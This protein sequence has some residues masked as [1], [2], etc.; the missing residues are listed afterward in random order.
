MTNTRIFNRIFPI[1]ILVLFIIVFSSQ[2]LALEYTGDK[3]VLING[4]P[5]VNPNKMPEEFIVGVT[6]DY[7]SPRFNGSFQKYDISNS[8]ITY[9]TKWVDNNE[10]H[11]DLYYTASLPELPK[12]LN[13]GENVSLN[14]RISGGGDS[15]EYG[16]ACSAMLQFEYRASGVKLVGGT[17]YTICMDFKEGNIAPYFVVPEIQ[18]GGKI[19]ISAFLW[20][21][22]ACLVQWVYEAGGKPVDL[23]DIEEPSI[24]S[25]PA[26]GAPELIDDAD[27]N[28]TLDKIEDIESQMPDPVAE[29]YGL[30]KGGPDMPADYVE[31]ISGSMIPWATTGVIKGDVF[32]FQKGVGKWKGP[33]GPNVA[34]F[35]GDTIWTNEG[36]WAEIV[37]SGS[38][39]FAIAQRTML[40]TGIKEKGWLEWGAMLIWE[41][42]QGLARDERPPVEIWNP[43][44]SVAP[45]G[46]EYII[47]VDKETH[48]ATYTV[49]EGIVEVWL[50]DDPSAKRKIAAGESARV[51]ETRIEDKPYNWDAL[52]EKYNWTDIDLSEPSEGETRSFFNSYAI[53]VA[54][55]ILAIIAFIGFKKM[56]S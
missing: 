21:C 30:P 47:E 24:E 3:W 53:F 37:R 6:K 55:I 42:I 34:I 39:R 49:R 38:E 29:K 50:K 32:I 41:N 35:E 23:V 17:Q 4:T 48:I 12:E 15:G 27:A 5:S 31:D 2:A 45:R 19:I 51:T 9:S 28:D 10:T 25:V 56:R 18:K 44:S 54:F 13:P 40:R 52:L 36:G 26:S 43:Y 33:I 16:A 1:P 46:T 22:G 8:A 14:T 11:Y 20:N 7:Y